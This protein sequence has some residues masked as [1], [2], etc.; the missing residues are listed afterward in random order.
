M[1]KTSTTPA[2]NAVSASLAPRPDIVP[3]RPYVFP[4]VRTGTVGSGRI[5]AA[6]LPGQPIAWLSVLLDGGALREPAGLEGLARATAGL[7]DE[8]TLKRSAD[9][10]GTA[11]ESLGGN[12]SV[13]TGWE[14]VR[15]SLDLPVREAAAG[16][17]LLAEAVRTPAFGDTDV[18]RYLADLVASKRESF[19][20]PGPR[21]QA[22]LRSALYGSE[23]RFGLLAGG[24]PESVAALDA[25]AVRAFHATWL[26]H[27][28]TLLIAGDLDRLDVEAL[29]RAV[30]GDFPASGA[31]RPEAPVPLSSPRRLAVADRAGAVQSTLRIGHPTVTRSKAAEHGIDVVALRLGSTILGGSFT[32]RLNHELR[33]VKGYTYGAHA[34]FDFGRPVGLFSFAA[35]VRT[36]ATADA[37]ADTLRVIGEYVDGGATAQ[38]I[39]KTR[40]YLA[41]A[42][43]IGL[44][45]VGAVGARLVEMVRHGLP[46]DY[47]TTEHARLLDVT[48]DEVNAA[49]RAALHPDR[50]VVAVE[51][52]FEVVGASLEALGL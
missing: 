47:V 25:E 12:W 41:G 31:A 44:Q 14:T 48:P 13:D 19:A 28:G 39:E 30:F 6:H 32:S 2:G 33:E 16:A 11:V 40:A 3:P 51:G 34:G 22:A 9:E 42:T 8:G 1:T 5:L 36:D 27:A 37:V 24:D 49:V 17:D 23:T 15:L 20:R 26:R 35:E 29:G 46:A 18:E 45:T 7:L 21:A 52:D 43:P 4:E 38:E 50:L 10:F